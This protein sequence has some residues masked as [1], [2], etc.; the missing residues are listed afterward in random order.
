M[1]KTL[2]LVILLSTKIYAQTNQVFTVTAYCGC[3]KCCGKWAATHKTADG[4]TPK[5]G[6]T[7]AAPRSVPFGTKLDIEGVGTRIVQDRL[8]KK[9][10]GR[11]DIYFAKHSEALKFGKKRLAVKVIK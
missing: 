4:H 8:A 7:C 2:L 6:I 10:D 11:I 5:E 3:V 9:Y 1:I